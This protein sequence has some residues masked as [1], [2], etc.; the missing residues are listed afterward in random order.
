MG[1]A[2]AIVLKIVPICL[3][4]N[5]SEVIVGINDHCEP[6]QMPIRI[7]PTYNIPGNPEAII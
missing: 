6:S 1:H 7:E 4:P 3:T 5:M 2:M